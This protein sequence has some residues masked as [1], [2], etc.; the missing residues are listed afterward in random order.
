MTPLA[1]A[2]LSGVVVALATTAAALIAAAIPA[3]LNEVDLVDTEQ[4]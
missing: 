3:D 4:E 1:V 2:G